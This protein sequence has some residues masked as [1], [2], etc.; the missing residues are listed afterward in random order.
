MN[1]TFLPSPS[2]LIHSS[3]GI[4]VSQHY[5]RAV[6]SR[7]AA[8]IAGVMRTR[9]AIHAEEGKRMRLQLGV[10]PHDSRS[11]WIRLRSTCGFGHARLRHFLLDGE[12]CRFG[13][14]FFGFL[15]THT[16][17]VTSAPKQYCSI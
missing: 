13:G 12:E 2:V 15:P 10:T 1:F 5:V 8:F 9:P 14:F 3:S 6:L 11:G 7:G 4:V 17:I 16:I